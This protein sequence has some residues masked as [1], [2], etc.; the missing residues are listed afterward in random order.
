MAE[1]VQSLAAMA[2]V[3]LLAAP[4]AAFDLQGHRGARGLAPEN[5]LPGFAKALEIGVDTLEMDLGVTKGGVV[6]VS[7]DP[8][9]NADITRGPDGAWL[10]STGPALHE[11]ELEELQRYDVGRIRPGSRY[12]ARFP[13]QEPVDGARIPTLAEVVA[14]TRASGADE[15]R[16]NLE[17]KIS[18]TAPELT[19]APEDFARAVVDVV[20]AEGIEGRTTIQ[21][22]DW[23]TLREVQRIAPEIPTVCLTVESS[24]LDNLMR[25][26]H[27]APPWTAGFD[28]DDFGGSVPDLVAAAGCRVWSPEFGDLRADELARAHELGL[29]VI[30]WTVNERDDMARLLEMG[31]DGIITDYPDRLR[32]VMA[33]RGMDLPEPTLSLV[34]RGRS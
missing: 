29:G 13:E 8:R 30:V 21:S 27:G 18:P 5:T 31:V 19:P 10:R 16:F 7:H 32:E 23:R 22:F 34:Q 20:R 14:L 1:R 33:A 24:W 12:A 26:R 28:V 17:T 15:V 2:F 9:L 11:L 4:A 25:G 6:V 3:A